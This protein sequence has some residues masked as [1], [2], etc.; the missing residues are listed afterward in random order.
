M[1]FFTGILQLFRGN[2]QQ[3]ADIFGHQHEIDVSAGA[4]MY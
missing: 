2:M 1:P 3:F 4:N